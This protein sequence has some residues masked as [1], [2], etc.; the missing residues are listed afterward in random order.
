VH[1]F[2]K[3]R[4]IEYKD[5]VIPVWSDTHNGSPSALFP[6]KQMQLRYT[7]C[8]PTPLQRL[9]HGQFDEMLDRIVQLRVGK[10]VVRIFNGD[11]VEGVHHN[12]QQI[13][14]LM[15]NDHKLI[16]TEL[17]DYAA[18]RIGETDGDLLYYVAGTDSH[19]GE[20]EESLAKYLGAV[21]YSES[22]WCHPV[23]KLN[24]NGKRFWFA[25]QGANPGKDG[26]GT[27]GNGLR[28]KLKQ[29]YNDCIERGEPHPDTVIFSHFHHK[30]HEQIDTRRGT[31][32]GF[33]LPS[34]QMK[35]D[36]AMRYF[37]FEVENIGGLIMTVSA[38][39]V[40]RWEWSCMEFESTKE[41]MI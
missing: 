2:L 34:W 19:A 21:P 28:N 12:N 17:M 9:I 39:G 4:T 30:W 31:I 13:M 22:R 29:I 16:H 27:K 1:D 7:N 36:W 24:I 15:M 14:S 8:D 35:T 38:E 25:H 10:R 41:I 5:T 26:T 37:P 33:V 40:I 20:A 11:A 6:L 18:R 32:D 23:L 3:S